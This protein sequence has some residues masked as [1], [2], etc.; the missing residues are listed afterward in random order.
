MEILGDFQTSVRKALEEIDPTYES[1]PGLVVCGS[2]DPKNTEQIIEKIYQARIAWKPMLL[3]CMGHQL[4]AIE[5]ARNV[6]GIKDATSQEFGQPG[7]FVVRKRTELKVGLFDGES[8]W[9]N[10]EVDDEILKRWERP[11]HCFSSQFHPEYES[12]RFEP[13]PL[14]VTFLN[15]ARRLVL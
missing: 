11:P 13:H 9:N 12:S 14:L 10:Y 1:Y 2:H 6:L 8:Y 7:T 3:I 4:G 5:Y 15:Y